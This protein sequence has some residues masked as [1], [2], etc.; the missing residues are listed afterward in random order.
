MTIRSL[1]GDNSGQGLVEYALILAFVAVIAIVAFRTL[2]SRVGGAVGCAS[3][4]IDHPITA[5]CGPG[6]T[7]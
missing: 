7:L 2:G 1:L 4:A 3:Q 6:G 5:N